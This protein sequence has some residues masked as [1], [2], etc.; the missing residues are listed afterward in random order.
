MTGREVL[1]TAEGRIR[2]HRT[3][4]ARLRFVAGDGLPVRGFHGR[5]R[6]V[7]HEFLLGCNAFCIEGID[8][9]ACSGSMPSAT[10]PC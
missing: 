3:A 7:R 5:V 4:E 10:R 8:E 9:P 6:L 2:E 1:E